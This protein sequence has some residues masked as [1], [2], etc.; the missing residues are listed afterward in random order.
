MIGAAPQVVVPHQPVEVVGSG[1]S[2]IDLVVQYFG[3]RM[4]VRADFLFHG[5][6]AFEWC[7]LRHIHNHLE[8]ALVVKRQ[9]LHAYGLE[10]HQRAGQ[11]Q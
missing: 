11:Q 5:E 8:L 2:G 10:R 7:A 4:Q 6:R 3:L 9:H 1:G